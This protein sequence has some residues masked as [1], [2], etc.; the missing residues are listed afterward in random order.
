M[1]Y[2]DVARPQE[3]GYHRSSRTARAPLEPSYN[4]KNAKDSLWIF[5]RQPSE[6]IFPAAGLTLRRAF[7][8]VSCNDI[9]RLSYRFTIQSAE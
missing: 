6:S 4:T 3:T 2:G 8:N 9:I 7:R 5:S 1:G